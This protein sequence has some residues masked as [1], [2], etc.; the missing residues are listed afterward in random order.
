MSRPRLAAALLLCGLLL[1]APARAAD[2]SR[3]SDGRH[4]QGELKHVNGL[5]VLV[6]Q[7][8]P[9]EMG[10]Q[11]GA[12]LAGP[13]QKLLTYPRDL[14]TKTA[15]EAVWPVFVAIAKGMEPQ[16]PPDYLKE[17]DAAARA[18]QLDR[19]LFLIGN[20]FPDISKAYGCSSLVIGKERSATGGPLLGRN[21]DYPALGLLDQ[22]NL[23]T[24]RRPKGKHSFVSIGFP[25]M[26]GIVSGMNDAGLALAVHE[27]RKAKDGTP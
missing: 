27:V 16:F 1:S 19:N 9:E 18:S 10:E 7:G 15:G 4:G 2:D 12:L 26:V 13:L 20:T 21:L 14:V 11:E 17:L 23:V 22:Y 3:Y 24:V 8:T 5:P 25:G 6:L